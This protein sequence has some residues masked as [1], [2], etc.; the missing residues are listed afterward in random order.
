MQYVSNETALLS[1]YSWTGQP[2]QTVPLVLS[3]SFETSADSYLPQRREFS[4]AM[5]ATFQAFDETEKNWARAAL[6]YWSSVS[7]VRFVEGQAGTGD[8]RFSEFTFDVASGQS[9]SQAFTYMPSRSLTATSSSDWLQG[10]DI[11]VNTRYGNSPFVM[12]HEIGHALSLKHPFDGDIRLD[13]SLDNQSN[14]VMSYTGSRPYALG[15]LDI[16]AVRDV[17]GSTNPG[18]WSWNAAT[19]ELSEWTLAG[20][21][22]LYGT[23]QRDLLTGGAGNDLIGGFEGDDVLDGGTGADTLIGGIGNDTYIVDNAGD[24]V[25]ENAGEGT[26]LVKSSISYTLGANL[27]NLTLTGTANLSGTGTGLGNVIVGNSGDN[28]LNGAGGNDSL[29][30]GAGRDVAL[31]AGNRAGYTISADAAGARIVGAGVNDSLNNVEIARFADGDVDLLATL[32]TTLEA[33][34]ATRLVQ[35]VNTFFLRAAD[36][37]GPQLRYQGSVVH[38]NQFSSWTPLGAERVGTGYEVA[39]RFGTADQYMV[40]NVAGD[41]SYVA[42]AIGAVSGT[43]NQLRSTET[44][45]QQ[46]LNGDGVIGLAAATIE[47][48]GNTRLVQAGTV[49][50]MFDAQGQGPTLAYGGAAVAVGQFG[51]WR[52]IGAEQTASGYDIAWRS[53]TADLYTVWQVGRDGAYI[54]NR[55]GAVIGADPGLQEFETEFQQ[56]FNGDGTLGI[57]ATV[58]ESFGATKLVQV[59]TT[60]HLHDAQDQGGILSYQGRAFAPG[61]FAAWTPIG[62]EKVGSGY[63][64]AWRYGTADLYTVWQVGSGGDYIQSLLGAVAGSD[65][66]LQALETTLQQDLNGDGTIGTHVTVI[67]S[68]GATHLE[69]VGNT[70][71]LHDAQDQ[72]PI[73]AY[74][75]Q[76][77]VTGAFAAWTPFAAAKVDGGYDVAWRYGSADLFTVWRVGNDGSYVGNLLGAVPKG[78]G[79][80]QAYEP[81]FGQDLDGDGV[82]GVVETVL[83]SSGGTKLVHSEDQYM[84]RDAQGNGPTLKYLGAVVYEQNWGGWSA[85]GVERNAEGYQVAWKFSGQDQ[86]AVWQTDTNG[87]YARTLLGPISG[88][89]L[90]FQDVEPS[91][92]QDLNGDGRIGVAGGVDGLSSQ[93][94]FLPGESDPVADLAN[95]LASFGPAIGSPDALSAVGSPEAPAADETWRSTLYAGGG[96][97]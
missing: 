83:E 61:Q 33:Q 32:T 49:F 55:L 88:G 78:S 64:V 67:G 47:A 17:F 5:M 35:V 41:G 52:P 92:Q 53:G 3:Y 31:F 30:G 6:Q 15:W 73:L 81:I 34:G 66:G 13:L 27:E 11:F 97:A 12:L 82:I 7:G 48:L 84:L 22:T 56:D 90:V 4:S 29:D 70:Y 68:P 40:W 69:V 86:F 24:T 75:G 96:Y 93:L 87:N 9:G 8:I 10:G 76:T 43:D 50:M 26:D 59:G 71:H 42:T 38:L 74:Q 37:S 60:F 94:L 85:I 28:L 57:H 45:F 63:D 18:N 51:A 14:T 62:V 95:T 65:S 79:A 89:D 2:G 46:D 1:S 44:L 19:Q 80:F 77:V 72:G 23:G 54:A 16:A 21:T 36:G 39:W 91:F 20:Q 25:I 58:I